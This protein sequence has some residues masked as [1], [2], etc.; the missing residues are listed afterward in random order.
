MTARQ[1]ANKP[2]APSEPTVGRLCLYRA[3]LA[4]LEREGVE[5]VYS[6]QLAALAGGAASRVRRDLMVVGYDG[7]PTRG[8]VVSDL[9]ASIGSF[10]DAPAQEGVALV[11]V[12]N[13]GRALMAFFA[14]RRPNLS[15]V[16]A[17]DSD[18]DKA[19]RVIHGCRCHP[20]SALADVV[21]EKGIRVAV[22]SVPAG[23]A[24][25]VADQLVRAGVRGLLNFAPVR[26][27]VPAGVFVENMDMAVSLEKVAYFA[28]Q[29][30]AEEGT[31]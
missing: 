14:G 5:S 6:H 23:E 24:Q 27:R 18:P 26:L 3:L 11:G 13:L 1:F 2:H 4:R 16:A 22:L 19:E 21:R 28:R 10:L 31:D 8:Y 29:S 9:L 15:I 30:E 12:G 17:F 20:M 25:V 7:S